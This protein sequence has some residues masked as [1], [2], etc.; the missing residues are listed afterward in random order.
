MIFAGWRSG[1]VAGGFH[2]IDAGKKEDEPHNEGH[3]GIHLAEANAANAQESQG[4]NDDADDAQNGE[5]AAKGAFLIHGNGFGLKM[6]ERKAG[7]PAVRL[8]RQLPANG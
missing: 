2:Q 4:G 5:N 7:G 3:N 6:V 1:P 8:I